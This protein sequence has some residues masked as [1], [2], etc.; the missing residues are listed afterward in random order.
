MSKLIPI[1][2]SALTLGL[3]GGCANPGVLQSSAVNYDTQ[4]A[5]QMQQ[6]QTG[7]VLAVQPVNIA[8]SSTGIGT[9]GG[10]A[11][12]ALAGSSLG[13]GHGSAALGIIG[14]LAGGIAGSALE[15]HA[16]AQQGYQITVKL[17]S[18]QTV[19]VTQAAD[20]AVRAGMRVEI[21]GGGYYGAGPAR[22]LPLSQ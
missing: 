4:Q 14:A 9:L 12:G 10:A 13:Q 22:V 18:G 21:V 11:A 6:V 20:I 16:L 15:G 1:I 19:A 2:A 17:D 3:L 8:P 7:I 5:G